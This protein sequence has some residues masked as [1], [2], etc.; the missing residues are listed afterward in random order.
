S[1]STNLITSHCDRAILLEKGELV[2][3]G[4][5]IDI[6]D[7]YMGLLFGHRVSNSDNRANNPE[8]NDDAKSS[9]EHSNDLLKQFMS[10]DDSVGSCKSRSGYNPSER[11]TG[12]RTAEVIDYLIGT[13]SDIDHNTIRLTDTIRLFIKVKF[14]NPVR[15]PLV[16]FEVKT[17]DGILVYGTN[18]YMLGA[19][20]K[21]AMAG[22]VRVFQF[23]FH[24]RLSSGDYFLNLG[25]AETDGTPGGCS[26]N[27]RLSVVHIVLV[28][29]KPTFN[30]LANLS[31][32]FSDFSVAGHEFI[33]DNVA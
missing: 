5:P 13:Y 32:I 15:H 27:V 26:P 23:D 9:E 22:E 2:S 6:V 19:G 30:G 4:E 17:V 12:D 29:E 31:P 28:D 24:P 20:V 11:E 8:A 16:G 7:E 3:D 10:L 14:H 18:T 21:E 1:H 33:H 25:I